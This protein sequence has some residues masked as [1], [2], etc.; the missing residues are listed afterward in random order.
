LWPC[1]VGGGPDTGY[2]SPG[3]AATCHAW[4]RQGKRKREKGEGRGD[5][6]LGPTRG[7]AQL[8]EARERVTDGASYSADGLD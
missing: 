2:S 5:R 6:R 4:E 7:G 3:M 8:I 1:S